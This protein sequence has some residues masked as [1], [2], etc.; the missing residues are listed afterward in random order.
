MNNKSKN[1]FIYGLHA[2]NE[3]IDS[4]K[5]IDKILIKH[6]ITGAQAKELRDKAKL[7]KIPVL[8][9]P[10]EKINRITR[11]NHQGAIAFI[12][13]IA[14]FDLEDVLPNI[15]DS[16]KIPLLIILDKITDVRNFGAIARTA[17]CMGVDAIVVPAKGS[18]MITADAVKTSAGA[19]HKI[20]VCRVQ[21]I[22]KTA[23]YLKDYGIKLVSITEKSNKLIS[24]VDFTEPVALILGNEE[25]GI[26]YELL[27]KSD[28]KAKIPMSGTIES[29]N[30]SV[31]CSIAIYEAVNQRLKQ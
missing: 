31:A 10:I 11:K 24:E 17:E 30:V 16:G 28:E 7:H 4:G 2:I 3:A 14:Y 6:D 23:D 15:F 26:S 1:N 5:N 22:Y 19:L 18:A 21:D 9:V 29:L 13:E 12:S 27:N 8:R 20:P 25:K